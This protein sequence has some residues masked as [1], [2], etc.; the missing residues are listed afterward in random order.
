MK[1]IGMEWKCFGNE[2]E[3]LREGLPRMFGMFEK[4]FIR[5]VRTAR[6]ELAPSSRHVREQLAPSSRRAR[7]DCL[8]H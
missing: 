3:V 6:A 7:T 1:C 5:D 4:V 2:V 8:E